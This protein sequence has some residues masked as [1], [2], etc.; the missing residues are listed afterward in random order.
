[1]NLGRDI[2]NVII[3]LRMGLL[4]RIKM[5]VV[6][7]QIN[8]DVDYRIFPIIPGVFDYPSSRMIIGNR[9]IDYTHQIVM[10]VY[11]NGDS[12]QEEYLTIRDNHRVPKLEIQLIECSPMTTY[13]GQTRQVLYEEFL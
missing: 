13:E 4:E 11:G 1:M 10:D 12:H 9:W 3:E 6:I 5:N 7:A 8:R 2:E